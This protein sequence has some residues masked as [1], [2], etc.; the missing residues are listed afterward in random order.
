MG[1][2][3]CGVCRKK[4]RGA[5]TVVITGN[6]SARSKTATVIGCPRCVKRGFVVVPKGGTAA[7]GKCGAPASLC[8]GCARDREPR[9]RAKLVEDVVVLLEGRLRAFKETDPPVED[10]DAMSHRDGK[11]EAYEDVID[12][13]RGGRY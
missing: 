11:I 7:C 3:L 4:Y 6:D 10:N 12:T 9:D 2:R 8:G 1:E 5:G 13:L